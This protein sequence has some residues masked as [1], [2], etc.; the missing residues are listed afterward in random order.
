VLRR[1]FIVFGALLAVS[2]VLYAGAAALTYSLTRALT[3][4]DDYPTFMAE[5]KRH[6]HPRTYDQ[7]E[8]AFSE[9]VTR[10][11]P[12]GSSADEAIAKISGGGFSAT[13]HSDPVVLVWK[14]AAGPCSEQYSIVVLKDAAGRIANISGTLYPACL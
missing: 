2:V 7:A 10:S 11:F 3:R 12:I 4:L 14:R 6:D 13:S 5:L 1:I 9:F 8:L